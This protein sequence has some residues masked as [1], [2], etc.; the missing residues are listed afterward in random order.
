MNERKQGRAGKKCIMPLPGIIFKSKSGRRS[1][2]TPEKPGERQSKGDQRRGE[3][4]RGNGVDINCNS[5]I[6]ISVQQHAL[7]II[8]TKMQ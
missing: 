7:K 2:G 1:S 4:R 8:K 5:A 3:G 6:R